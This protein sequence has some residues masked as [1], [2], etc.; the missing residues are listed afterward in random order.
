MPKTRVKTKSAN[1]R[2]KPMTRSEMLKNKDRIAAAKK[3][4][5]TRPATKKR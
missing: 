3:K 5:N 2:K 4:K 1:M